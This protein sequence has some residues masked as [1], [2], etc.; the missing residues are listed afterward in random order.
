MDTRSYVKAITAL[1]SMLQESGLSWILD[2]VDKYF[3]ST[4]FTKDAH[5]DASQLSPDE[6]K[7]Y[8]L[9]IIGA[10]RDYVVT[11]FNMLT[12]FFE[13][14]N[15]HSQESSQLTSAFSSISICDDDS[16]LSLNYFYRDLSDIQTAM[17]NISDSLDTMEKE[18]HGY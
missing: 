2:D 7:K 17:K 13:N 1:K 18:I 14:I 8:T 3:H 16:T 5:I 12:N 6:I 15:E 10:M 4:L 11:P 9:L